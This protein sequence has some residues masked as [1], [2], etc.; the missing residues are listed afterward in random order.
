M[1]KMR[2]DH[3]TLGELSESLEQMPADET[4]TFDFCRFNPTALHSYRGYYQDLAIG[5]A[6]VAWDDQPK[7][8]AFLALLKDAIG[9]EYPGWK[10]GY[11]TMEHRTPLWV[12]P[13]E[14]DGG[15]TIVVGAEHTSIAVVIKTSHEDCEP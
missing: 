12:S 6:Q 3:M 4:I 7:T 11:Y 10:G 13:P 9:K 5:Y 1:P 15:G 8:G 2:N 14:G